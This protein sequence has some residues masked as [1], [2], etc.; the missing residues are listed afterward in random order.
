MAIYYFFSPDGQ[1]MEFGSLI[2]TSNSLDT[3]D[4][5]ESVTI[6]T[7]H[8]LLMTLGYKAELIKDNT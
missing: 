4:G 3:K 8:P 2:S 6:T 7:S 1:S 5:V